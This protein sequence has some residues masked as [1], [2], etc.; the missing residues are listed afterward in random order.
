MASARSPG[1]RYGGALAV[2]AL[3]VVFGDIGTS[4]LY[5]L[6]ECLRPGHGLPLTPATVLG[7]LSLL[8]WALALIVSV[9]YILFVMRA[10][11]SG[12]GGI[13]AL[14]ALIPPR[15]RGPAVV[16]L[17]LFGAALLYGDGVITPA[18]S[19]LAAVE[20]LE[21]AAPGLAPWV[22]PIAA[23]LLLLLFT[24]QKR[25]TAGVGQLFGPV[26]LVWFIAIAWLGA[27]EVWRSPGILRALSPWYGMRLLT[28]HRAAAFLVLGAVVLAVTGAEALYADMGHLGRRPIRLAWL[29]LVFPS[30][31][32]NYLG[33]AALVLRQPE[34]VQS[35]FY[36]LAPRPLLYPLLGLATLA[37]IIASQALISGAFS[38]TS[39]AV[40]L[41]YFPRVTIVHTSW[42]EA[43][44]V[45]LPEVNAGLMVGCLLLV[46]GFRS[47]SALGAAYGIAVT[48][49]MAVTSVLF[50]L[51]ARHRWRWSAWH[52]GGL[53]A[54]FLAVDLA[55]LGANLAKVRA[56]GWVPLAIAAAVYILLSTWKRGS[57]LMRALLARASV[58]FQPFLDRLRH[59]PPP[60]V[61]GTAVFLS[62]T[63]K[64]V[65]PVLLNH[66]EHNKALHEHVV[67]LTVLTADEPAVADEKR[68]DSEVLAP[69][70]HRVRARY[71]FMEMPD[72]PAVLERCCGL[73][74][75][76]RLEET[77]YYVGRTRVLPTGPAPMAKWRKLLF[78]F[79]ARNARSATEYFRIPPDRVVELGAQIQL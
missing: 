31:L 5:A 71:G 20:G 4:P 66:L 25:G 48:G 24:L 12:E 47:S 76:S 73:G 45:Y 61:P 40:R 26:M 15:A 32:L 13:L 78:G 29:G 43:G 42:T 60:R 21:V 74:I 34:A 35:P 64:G 62:A 22:V 7:V 23:A 2:T 39:Q 58:P 53:A 49:T 57:E 72:V 11:N 69:R 56:G 17:G 46:L 14:L 18:I 75:A 77:S 10:D 54:L 6:R 44:Q 68:I 41:G 36:L 33:Q 79:L 65:P 50:H 52:A 63:A 55:F 37:T 67:I 28:E 9:K 30:L 51:V 19:V 8:V 1:R 38:L 27:A 70:F 16:A 59:A 3:G